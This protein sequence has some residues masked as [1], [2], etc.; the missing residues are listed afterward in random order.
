MA[1]ATAMATETATIVDPFTGSPTFKDLVVH[2]EAGTASSTK[3]STWVIVAIACG[4]FLLVVVIVLIV[5]FVRP[6]RTTTRSASSGN[7]WSGYLA[8]SGIMTASEW[9]GGGGWEAEE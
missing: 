8:S 4:I 6:E 9:Y 3:L 1:M 2:N 7:M 5:C